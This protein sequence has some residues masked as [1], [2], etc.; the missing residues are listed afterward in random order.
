M[1]SP[2]G[3]LGQGQTLSALW[4]LPQTP[5][6]G[7][8]LLPSAR[9]AL[10]PLLHLSLYRTIFKMEAKTRYTLDR[11]THTHTGVR[12]E[13]GGTPAAL[14]EHQGMHTEPLQLGGQGL[15]PL[16][17]QSALLPANCPASCQRGEGAG[18]A[19]GSW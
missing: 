9:S 12:P 13:Q 6:A 10:P 15:G 16:G 18:R 8:R 7:V 2:R 19:G 3:S 11:H 5:G 17:P 4:L 14:R 1:L